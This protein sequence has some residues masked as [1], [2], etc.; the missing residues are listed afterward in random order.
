MAQEAGVG[1]LILTHISARYSDDS[2]PLAREGREI[3]PETGVAQDGMAIE[4]EYRQ[5][6]PDGDEEL[7]PP[8]SDPADE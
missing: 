3:F 4:L 7:S 5:D 8:D 2:G 1:R 6:D